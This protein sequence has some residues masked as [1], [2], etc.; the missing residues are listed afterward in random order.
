MF[1]F[2]NWREQRQKWSEFEGEFAPYVKDIYRVA[3]FLTKN[4]GEAEDLAQD[5]IVQAL[6][7]FHT[8]EKGTNIRAWMITIMYRQHAKQRIKS[9]KLPVVKE[10]DDSVMNAT[11]YVPPVPQHITDDDIRA[12]IERLPTK[13]SEPVLLVDVEEFKYAE[14]ADILQIPI[15]TVMSRLHR[16]RKLL[17]VELAGYAKSIGYPAAQNEKV[18]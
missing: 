16:G 11:A 6:L 7:Y 4:H 12:A 9:R 2:G 3:L 8:Y 14:I 15:G 10:I 5:T 13:Y 17:R 1:G 18:L